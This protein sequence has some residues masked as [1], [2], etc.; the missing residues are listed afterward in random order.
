MLKVEQIKQLEKRSWIKKRY[1]LI[2]CTN[3]M[4]FVF[5]IWNFNFFHHSK[6]HASF[7]NKILQYTQKTLM[8][9]NICSS[10]AQIFSVP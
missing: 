8:N 2:N 1:I 5:L 6:C 9:G 3:E 4:I 7:P 10:V